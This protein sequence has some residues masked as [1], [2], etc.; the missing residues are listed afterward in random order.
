METSKKVFGRNQGQNE[1]H[2]NYAASNAG[3]AERASISEAF[4][5]KLG[6]DLGG[7]SE[8]VNGKAVELL[9]FMDMALEKDESEVEKEKHRI[10]MQYLSMIYAQRPSP[11]EKESPQTRRAREEFVQAIKPKENKQIENIG[12]AKV[13]DWDFERMKLLKQKQKGG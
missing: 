4:I 1:L 6:K 11:M 3:D 10:W 12:P 5:F 8:V 7:R 9:K 2:E 13:Y